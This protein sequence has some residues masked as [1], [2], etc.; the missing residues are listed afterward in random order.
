MSLRY[1]SSSETSKRGGGVE[2]GRRGDAGRG[3]RVALLLM[4]VVAGPLAA[5]CFFYLCRLGL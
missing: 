5:R 3:E 1:C 2:C 4:V